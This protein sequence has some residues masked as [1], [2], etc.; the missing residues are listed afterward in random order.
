M[1]K[2]QRHVYREAIHRYKRIWGLSARDD[3][4]KWILDQIADAIKEGSNALDAAEEADSP[5]E[6]E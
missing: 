5:P 3:V 1:D 4:P 6:D 2:Q